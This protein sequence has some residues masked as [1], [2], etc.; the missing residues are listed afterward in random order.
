MVAI[1]YLT[2]A[3]LTLNVVLMWIWYRRREIMS[4]VFEVKAALQDNAVSDEEYLK[5]LEKLENILEK[6]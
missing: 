1:E 5:I 2:A 6:K 3:S 4:A